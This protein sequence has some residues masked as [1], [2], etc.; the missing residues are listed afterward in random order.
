MFENLFMKPRTDYWLK[1]PISQ[2]IIQRFP[3][4]LQTSFLMHADRSPF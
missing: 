2:V 1:E 4:G 3:F